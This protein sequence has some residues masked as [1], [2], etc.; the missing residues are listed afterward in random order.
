MRRGVRWLCEGEELFMACLAVFC[1]LFVVAVGILV[2]GITIEFQRDANEGRWDYPRAVT[3]D[4][5]AVS[6]PGDSRVRP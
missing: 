4:H 2:V 3:A 6:P 1:V 5:D